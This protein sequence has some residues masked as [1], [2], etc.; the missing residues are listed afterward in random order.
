MSLSLAEVTSAVILTQPENYAR[1][2]AVA[3]TRDH[4]QDMDIGR[5][6]E[7]LRLAREWSKKDLSERSGI[8]EPNLNRIISG[9][10]APTIK[11][12][13]QLAGAFNI[14]VYELIRLAET[15]MEADARKA[16][17]H[18]LIDDMSPEQLENAFRRMPESG[19]SS[20]SK[21]PQRSII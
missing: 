13:E 20:D 5:A 12:L 2:F 18:R 3:A 7:V 11:R 8:N 10:Q 17:L 1:R 15:G 19:D 9:K 4:A 16:L 14:Q 6:I 21:S